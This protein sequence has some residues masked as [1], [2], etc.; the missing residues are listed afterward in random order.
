MSD[1]FTMTVRQTELAEQAQALRLALPTERQRRFVEEFM[2]PTAGVLNATQ[3]AIR[4]GYPAGTANRMANRLMKKPRI[5]AAVEAMRAEIAERSAYTVERAML[6]LDDAMT[7]AKATDNASAFTRAVELRAR[8][9][10]VLVDR[11]DARVAVGTF[12][13]N[14]IGMEAANA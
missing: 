3:A 10:G 8:I 6:E 1:N 12:A 2:R 9:A 5:K 11:I 4:A 13:I 14:V 7:F